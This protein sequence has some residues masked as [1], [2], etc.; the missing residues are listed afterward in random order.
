VAWTQASHRLP[1]G[2]SSHSM[3]RPSKRHLIAPR[4]RPPCTCCPPGARSIVAS[5]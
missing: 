3:A 1:A 4:P 2:R 5:S